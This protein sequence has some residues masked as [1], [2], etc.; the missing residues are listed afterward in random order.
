MS[1]LMVSSQPFQ[2]CTRSLGGTVTS[3]MLVAGGSQGIAVSRSPT[4]LGLS[5]AVPQTPIHIQHRDGR[6][7]P[8][9]AGDHSSR[10]ETG[11]KTVNP[12]FNDEMFRIKPRRIYTWA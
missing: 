1:W 8:D 9:L 12:Y 7:C 10:F 2:R 6:T 3:G 11:G 4:R 5:L